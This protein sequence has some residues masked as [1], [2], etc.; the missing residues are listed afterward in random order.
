MTPDRVRLRGESTKRVLTVHNP[1]P[2]FT[3]V[4][5]YVWRLLEVP[6]P[7]TTQT[8]VVV[9]VGAIVVDRY[10]T[11]RITIAITARGIVVA[12]APSN[13]GRQRHRSTV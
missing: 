12:V 2:T 13:R 3:W 9:L 4:R 11:R 6:D 5:L 10:G 8:Q 7:V 1:M